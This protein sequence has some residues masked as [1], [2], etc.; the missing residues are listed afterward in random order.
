M[1]LEGAHRSPPS[2]HLPPKLAQP[3]LALFM[4]AFPAMKA[5]AVCLPMLQPLT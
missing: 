4:M 2:A 1:P 5:A 3:P